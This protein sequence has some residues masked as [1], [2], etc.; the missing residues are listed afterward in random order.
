MASVPY[1]QRMREVICREH[2]LIRVVPAEI[3]A[4]VNARRIGQTY[5]DPEAAI[6]ILGTSDKQPLT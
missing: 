2:G 5:A 3:L 6:E 4:E 1:F